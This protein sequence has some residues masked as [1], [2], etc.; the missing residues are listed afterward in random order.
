LGDDFT[1]LGRE[2]DLKDTA[3]KMADSYETNVRGVMGSDRG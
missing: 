1:F 2:R 3:T